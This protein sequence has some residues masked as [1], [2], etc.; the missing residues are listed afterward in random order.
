MQNKSKKIKYTILYSFHVPLLILAGIVVASG[1][2]AYNA[3]NKLEENTVLG[4]KVK[5]EESKTTG[6]SKNT[7]K[8]TQITKGVTSQAKKHE[9]NMSTVVT[10]LEE[11]AKIEE[12]QGNTEVS[13]EITELADTSETVTSDTVEAIDEIETRPTWKTTLLGPDYKNLG[14][15]RSALAHNDNAIRKLTKT[16]GEVTTES[17]TAVQ[18]Q[19]TTLLQEREQIYDIVKV[20]ES[21]FSLLGWV[22]RFLTGYK[23]LPAEEPNP[24]LTPT[25]VPTVP[26]STESTP[27]VTVSPT[28][29]PSGTE[30]PTPSPTT[31]TINMPTE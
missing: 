22:T 8:D 21:R 1:V 2:L 7:G 29:E 9:E 16:F 24:T 27:S 25:P 10:K 5:N 12:A 20:E 6:N 28:P 19:L 15:L 4:T 30:S 11:V 31:T 3:S 13:E 17:T 14:Q 26:E 23:P 18:T